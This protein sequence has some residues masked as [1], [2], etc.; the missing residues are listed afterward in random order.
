MPL[1]HVGRRV[2]EFALPPLGER[3]PAIEFH[4]EAELDG[5]ARRWPVSER[6]LDQTIVLADGA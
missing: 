5:A 4:L 3:L 6:G 2:Y 1:R